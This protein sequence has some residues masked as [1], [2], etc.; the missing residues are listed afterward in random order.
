MDMSPRS[1]ALVLSAVAIDEQIANA[2]AAA[3]AR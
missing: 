3:F 2:G 1:A